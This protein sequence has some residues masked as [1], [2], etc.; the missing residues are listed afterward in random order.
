MT[1]KPAMMSATVCH[2]GNDAD[3]QFCETCGKALAHICARCRRELKP[4]AQFCGGCGAEVLG[5]GVWRRVPV[6]HTEHTKPDTLSPGERRQLTVLF[7]DLVG[8]TEIAARL[9]PE[10]WHRISREYQTAA[11]DAV[12]H[13]GGHVDKYLGD[14]LVCFFGFP[15]AHEDA[16]ERA[17]RAG[18]AIVDAVHA[19]NTMV[20]AE[21]S[22]SLRV[23]VGMHTGPVVVGQGGGDAPD[24]FGDTPNVA[25]R[26]QAVAEPDTVLVSAA[27]HRLVAG[28]FAV[29]DRSA[30]QLK[31]VLEPTTLYRVLAPSGMRGR[32]AANAAHGLTPFVGRGQER[33]LVL[34][35]WEQVQEGDGQ[36]VLIGGE[37]GIGKSRLVQQFKADLGATPHT[38]LEC[39]C[40]PYHQHTPFYAAID[41]MQQSFAWP[42]DLPVEARLDGLAEALEIGGFDPAES[43]PVVARLLDLPVP[44]ERFPALLLS[45]EQQR[46]KLLATLVAWG[47]AA[48]RLQPTVVVVDDLHWADP[49]TLDFLALL[50]EQGATAPLLLLFTARPEF[51]PPWPLRAHHAQVTLNR[52]SKKHVREMIAQVTAKLVPS[53]AMV[54]ALLARTDGVPLFVEELTKAVVEAEASG[55]STREIP[56]TLQDSLMARLDRLGP[57][58]EVAL[59]ASVIGKE[60]SYTLLREVAG[61]RHAAPADETDLQAALATLA[62][63]ELIFTHGQLP[64]ATYTFK[65]ALIQETAYSALLKSRRRELHRA[66]ANVLVKAGGAAVQPALLAYHWEE[67]G[68]VEAAVAAWQQAAEQAHRSAAVLEPEAH[69][70]RALA[71]L[72]TRPDGPARWQLELPLQN[73][74]YSLLAG[75]RG[76]GDAGAAQALTRAGVLVEQLGDATQAILVLAGAWGAAAFVRTE[77]RAALAIAQEMERLAERDGGAVSRVMAHMSTGMPLVLLGELDS[78]RAHLEQ[79]LALFNDD[80]FRWFPFGPRVHTLTFL[81]YEAWLAGHADAARQR[82]QEAAEAAAQCGVVSDVASAEVMALILAALRRKSAGMTERARRLL[83]LCADHD[84]SVYQ[85][86]AQV[87]GGWVLACE[88]DPAEGIALLRDGLRQAQAAGATRTF[89]AVHLSLLAEVYA[90]GGAL[91]EALATLDEAFAAVGEEEIWRP[92]L[93]RLRGDL[94]LKTVD[95][96]QSIVE[97]EPT[98]PDHESR[99]QLTNEA[100]RCYREAIEL[101]HGMGAKAFELRAAMRLGRLL[102]SQGRGTEARELL[103]PLYASFTEGFDTRDLREAKALLE[104]LQDT[105]P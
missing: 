74:L 96:Q 78:G 2:E 65:H 47:I 81:A 32:L 24:V 17:V 95:S 6:P 14:G 85:S 87:F 90:R 9:D 43:V 4:Q 13:L 63:A 12:K 76:P 84:L 91:A 18:L 60:F 79:V 8:S 83:K 105:R 68:E 15:Q 92:D 30:Q 71:L 98:T 53:A 19:L 97:G 55:I 44:P 37:A 5:S 27:T 101:A 16:A 39:A 57:V 49:S 77:H 104:D 62:D 11:G 23:R 29:E 38:W 56:A 28:L 69:Y 7:C 1:R 20:T 67:A 26:V 21:H 45:P 94:L 46:K 61:A 35:R 66:V 93:L 99:A 50:A 72:A 48:A 34:D 33:E 103:A 31:G 89:L 36:V 3:A 25:A 42:A 86:A 59:I 52:L 41:L 80:D 51:R 10:D 88:E 70:R 75:T 102:Q 22:V 73:A 40:S 54:E 100:E 82:E 58:K 64:E